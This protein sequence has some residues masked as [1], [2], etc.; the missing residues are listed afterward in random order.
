MIR[1]A[2]SN[3]SN[4]QGAAIPRQLGERV[5]CDRKRAF[6]LDPGTEG[7]RQQSTIDTFGNYT[8]E[9]ESERRF[10]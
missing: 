1:D 9:V 10:E 5:K 7:M 4:A 6:L 8:T 2:A 3:V